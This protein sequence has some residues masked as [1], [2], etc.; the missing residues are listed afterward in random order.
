MHLLGKWNAWHIIG[1]EIDGV[2]ITFLKD[3][4]DFF[5]IPV[6]CRSFHNGISN[7]N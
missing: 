3:I 5:F 2:H 4:Q 7:S 6:S 1:L